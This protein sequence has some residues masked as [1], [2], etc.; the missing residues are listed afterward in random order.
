MADVLLFHHVQGL[1]SGIVAFADDLRAAGHTVHT[2]D[3]FAGRRFAS[4]DEGITHVRGIGFGE[5]LERGV[6]VAEG[7]P[8][9][10]VYAG[11]SLG[12]MPAQKL[13]QT[14]AGARGALFFESCLPTEEFG[15]VWPAG[16]PVQ[17]HGKDADPY[18]ATEGDLDAARALVEQLGPSGRA[19]LFTYPG[20]GHLF[21]DNSLRSY[22][23]EAASLLTSRV[24]RFLRDLG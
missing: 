13:A 9:D 10:V 18:F 6:R 2:P 12:V 14:R 23:P 19:E 16:V 21:A 5:V 15:D 24:L 3:L 22:D 20:D 17:I 8:D 11:F 7:L 1:T 4:I